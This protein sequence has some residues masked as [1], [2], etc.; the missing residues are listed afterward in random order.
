MEEYLTGNS[1]IS[2]ITEEIYTTPA[3][4]SNPIDCF[5]KAV[6]IIGIVILSLTATIILAIYSDGAWHRVKMCILYAI[7]PER[8]VSNESNNRANGEAS[9]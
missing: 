2:N 4:S 9:N 7:C 6:C 8:N 5:L 1:T 3:P